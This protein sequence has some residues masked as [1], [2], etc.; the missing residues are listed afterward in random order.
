[1]EAP[2]SWNSVWVVPAE[3]GAVSPTGPATTAPE[4]RPA[5]EGVLEA[6]GGGGS[7]GVAPACGPSGVPETG[8]TG[9]G[10]LVSGEVWALEP[11]HL[12]A[13]DAASAT[14]T[15]TGGVWEGERR[16]TGRSSVLGV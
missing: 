10:V 9:V 16:V 1:M 2:S 7:T 3:T 13:K 15:R 12:T 14:K 4:V 11:P 6:G 5:S 8:S